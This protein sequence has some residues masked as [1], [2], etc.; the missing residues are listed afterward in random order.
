MATGG[1]GQG[2]TPGL[3]PGQRAGVRLPARGP[4]GTPL[5][6]QGLGWCVL[7]APGLL[8]LWRERQGG[9]RWFLGVPE[10][11]ERELAVVAGERMERVLR[12]VGGEEGGGGLQGDESGGMGG[13]KLRGEVR[14]PLCLQNQEG[15]EWGGW[16]PPDLRRGCGVASPCAALQ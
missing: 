4:S 1:E 13:V 12:E 11:G 2:A 16:G 10:P 14:R 6:H 9:E 7:G 3:G 15:S 5:P 8:E